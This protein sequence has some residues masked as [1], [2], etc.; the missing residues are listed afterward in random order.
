MASKQQTTS[1]TKWNAPGWRIPTEEPTRENS[2]RQS[3]P[4]KFG[5]C[6]R[7]CIPYVNGNCY[8]CGRPCMWGREGE[9][10]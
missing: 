6:G 9:D 2:K 10:E 3:C 1:D 5:G 8:V 7:A 4:K